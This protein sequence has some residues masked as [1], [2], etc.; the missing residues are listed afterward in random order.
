MTGARMAQKIGIVPILR[1]G[2]GLVEPILQLIPEA[3]VLAFRDVSRRSDRTARRVLLQTT[4]WQPR[5]R[6]IGFGSHAGDR[7]FRFERL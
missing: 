1:A 5:R 6:R 4:Q 3:A 7:G 2:L